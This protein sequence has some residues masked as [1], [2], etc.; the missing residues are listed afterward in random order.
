[1]SET[2]ERLDVRGVLKYNISELSTSSCQLK[3]FR[4]NWLA[5]AT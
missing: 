1:M 3:L 5:H 4:L 2:Q